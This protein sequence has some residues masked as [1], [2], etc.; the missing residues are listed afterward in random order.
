M[1]SGLLAKN[2]MNQASMGAPP[3]GRSIAYPG[4]L[5]PR[6][7]PTPGAK[8]GPM[9]QLIVFNGV[10]VVLTTGQSL[11]EVQS[12]L[13]GADVVISVYPR[14]VRVLREPAPAIV[15]D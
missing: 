13:D 3:S 11:S 14:W 10:R 1:I 2:A 12:F 15:D 8:V 6:G 4:L 5:W 7:T 9:E